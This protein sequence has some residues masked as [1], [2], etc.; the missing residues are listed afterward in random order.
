MIY[1]EKPSDS[2]AMKLGGSLLDAF[3]FVLMV[4]IVTFVLVM[5]Y[6]YRCIKVCPVPS[7]GEGNY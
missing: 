7:S 1:Q 3:I 4:V 5:L 6:K 2:T